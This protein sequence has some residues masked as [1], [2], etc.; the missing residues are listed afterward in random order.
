M[1]IPTPTQNCHFATSQGRRS[2]QEDRVTCDLNFTIPLSGGGDIEEVMI[3]AVAVFDGHIGSSASNMAAR[4][5]LDKFMLNLNNNSI[6]QSSDLKEIL[7]SSLVTTI[8]D[9]DAEFTKARTILV[10]F[11]YHLYAGSTALIYN[12]HVLVANVGDSKAFLCYQKEIS[13]ENGAASLGGLFAKELTSDHNAHRL[14]EKARVEA[15]GG[16]FKSILDFVPLLMGHFPMTR[17]IGDVPLKRYGII[18]DPEVTDWL[19]LTSKDEFL[20]VASD[21]IFESVTPQAVCDFLNE[22]EDYSNPSLLAHQLIQKAYLEG[23]N[24]NLSVVL[25]PL[26]PLVDDLSVV[27]S[28]TEYIGLSQVVKV[29]HMKRLATCTDDGYVDYIRN[30]DSFHLGYDVWTIGQTTV[31]LIVSTP[32]VF[33]LTNYEAL[34]LIKRISYSDKYSIFRN[35]GMAEQCIGLPDSGVIE[36]MNRLTTF[37]DNGYADYIRNRDALH[38]G[39]IGMAEMCIELSQLVKIKQM[40]KFATCTKYVLADYVRSRD[41]FGLGFHGIELLKLVRLLMS[42]DPDLRIG[43]GEALRHSYFVGFRYIG[44]YSYFTF[45]TFAVLLDRIW[46]GLKGAG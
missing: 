11:E 31:D 5:F 6:E 46:Y 36:K 13:H 10:A 39:T 40:K 8:N 17:A 32:D 18:A 33:E 26:G 16:V 27:S 24:D 28:S 23:S 15:S 30:Q 45:L 43:V 29:K 35:A 9:I 44:M 38:L 7:K 2:Y 34:R 14:D 1:S 37:T 3:G 22:V 42:I 21:G 20:V 25:V 19:S 12:N 41:T 4:I